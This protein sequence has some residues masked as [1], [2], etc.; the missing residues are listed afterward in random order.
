M[1]DPE[2]KRAPQRPK[3]PVVTIGAAF[4]E[5]EAAR[6]GLVAERDGANRLRQLRFVLI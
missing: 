2:I 1:E 4:T 6:Q 3:M 5:E